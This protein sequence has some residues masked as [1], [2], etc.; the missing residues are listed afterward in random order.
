M[1]T[2]EGIWIS[3]EILSKVPY[4]L[5]N[6]GP[7][8]VAV[9]GA[10]GFIGSA[11][12]ASLTGAGHT[13]KP[14]SVRQDLPADALAGC[15]AVV[16]LAGEPIAQRWTDD[17]K[18][19]IQKSRVEG[20]RRVVAAMEQHRP[21]VLVSSS[22]INIY[23]DRGDDILTEAEPAADDFLGHVAADWENEAMKAEQYGVRVAVIRTGMVLGPGGA[24]E[25][26]LLPFKL[27]VGGKLGSG[28][29]WMSW[30]HRDDLIRLIEFLLVESTVRGVFN[31]VSPYPVPNAEFTKALGAA[32]HRPTIFPVP[33]FALQLLYGEMSKLLFDS[34]RAIPDAAS[35]AGFTFE[36]P[37][38]FGALREILD[39]Q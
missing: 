20:T 22:G 31:A 18:A 33:R 19:R 34:V 9:T 14:L 37:D 39:H 2:P 10:S 32:L 11:L 29:Q 24:L 25:K 12:T 5:R 8:T 21:T 27:G 17:A 36:H 38:I 16:H 4:Y 15:D 7:M 35:R 26:M 6:V 1:E 28:E 23:G 30:I 3:E 13:V